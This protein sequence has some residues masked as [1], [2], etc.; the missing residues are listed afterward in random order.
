MPNRL[1]FRQLLDYSPQS[2]DQTITFLSTAMSDSLE[3]IQLT[4]DTDDI[5][6]ITK[7]VLDA[8]KAPKPKPPW[9]LSVP[10]KLQETVRSN[11]LWSTVALFGLAWI[12]FKADP[13]YPIK[14]WA[15]VSKET[16]AQ[17]AKYDYVQRLSKHYATSGNALLNVDKFQDAEAA[18]KSA[19]EC[20]PYSK[21]AE[22][23]LAKSRLL[24]FSTCKE[25]DPQVIF[26]RISMLKKTI[27]GRTTIDAHVAYAEARLKYATGTDSDTIIGL[28][29]SAVEREKY[30]AAA[31]NLLGLAYLKK[32]EYERSEACLKAACINAP[33]NTDYLMNCATVYELDDKIDTAYSMLIRCRQIDRE[34]F[35]VT[36]EALRFNTIYF[37][38]LDY[39]EQTAPPVIEMFERDSLCLS[40]KNRDVEL[41]YSFGDSGSAT[42]KSW[43]AKRGYCLQLAL[44]ARCLNGFK[45]GSKPIPLKAITLGLANIWNN[46]GNEKQALPVLLMND[47]NSLAKHN[48]DRVGPIIAELKAVYR[49]AQ[50]RTTI[51]TVPIEF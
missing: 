30:Y 10:M 13:F 38:N 44:V 3:K 34:I 32:R 15:S 17:L 46:A 41:A 51:A 9:Y 2:A 37:L 23:G 6:R 7:T 16:N 20:D 22:F 1:I 25:F 19:V 4:A 5:A 12:F 40:P 33:Y 49:F 47:L 48:S 35:E 43:A 11:W 36:I 28:L 8:L 31:Q 29:K 50:E 18:F 39:V 26:E 42:I 45:P 21:E 24:S 14:K 27:P